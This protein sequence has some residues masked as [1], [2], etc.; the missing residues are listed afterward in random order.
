MARQLA[1]HI[2]HF[3]PNA[4]GYVFISARECPLNRRNFYRHHFKPA[5]LAV[6]LPERTRIHDLRHTYVSR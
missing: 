3:P 4:D 1:A 2:A 5:A 6:G